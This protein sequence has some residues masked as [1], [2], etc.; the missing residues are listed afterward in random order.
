MKRV[1]YLLLVGLCI[2]LG[3]NS[4]KSVSFED[5]VIGKENN[6]EVFYYKNK[7]YTGT[8]LK[9]ENG[10]LQ[11]RYNVKNGIKDGEYYDYD[12]D[13]QLVRRCSYKEGVLDGDDIR[14]RTDGSKMVKYPYKN[15]I[16]DG[17]EEMY[18]SDNTLMSRHH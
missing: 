16:L 4:E 5:I 13:G 2:Y 15:G 6:L 10:I 11:E 18:Y 12:Y 1:I 7:K 17:Y 8:I 9:Q 14:Y 3:C